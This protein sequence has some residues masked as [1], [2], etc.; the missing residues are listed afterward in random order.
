MNDDPE[1]VHRIVA[2]RHRE[3][4]YYEKK[5]LHN[6]TSMPT[7]ILNETLHIMNTTFHRT[8]T[9]HQNTQTTMQNWARLRIH[10][11]IHLVGHSNHSSPMIFSCLT[12]T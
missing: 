5:R 1:N 11:T 2:A 9:T 12:A 3:M 10:C 4:A 6:Q 8:K 7:H